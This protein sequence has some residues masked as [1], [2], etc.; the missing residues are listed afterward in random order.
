M[1]L[2]V[3]TWFGEMQS[4]QEL[5]THLVVAQNDGGT[6]LFDC[7]AIVYITSF[8]CELCMHARVYPVTC[9]KCSERF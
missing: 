4:L 8:C 3:P 1:T 7:F 6:V 5:N 2:K 9:I